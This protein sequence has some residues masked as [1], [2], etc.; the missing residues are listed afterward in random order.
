[1]YMAKSP[2]RSPD[3]RYNHTY[4]SNNRQHSPFSKF[5]CLTNAQPFSFASS[6][7]SKEFM[8]VLWISLLFP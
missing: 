3:S 1:M 4:Q 2:L 8:V 5:E 7:L 6:L